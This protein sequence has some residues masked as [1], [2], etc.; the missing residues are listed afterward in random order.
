MIR[1]FWIFSVFLLVAA[2]PRFV[3]A[4]ETKT[5]FRTAAWPVALRDDL[6]RIDRIEW[7]LRAA[8]DGMCPTRSAM[9]GFS[10][11]SLRAYAAGDRSLV[12]ATTGLG[13][14]PQILA[15]KPGGPAQEA[16]L[17]AGDD[18]LAIDG[19]PPEELVAAG[20]PDAL[21]ADGMIDA[22]AEMTPGRTLS[23]TYERDGNVSTTLVRLAA[24]CSVRV[25]YKT[26]RGIRA[27]SDARNVAVTAGLVRFVESDDELAL[28]LG[29]EMAH[30]ILE[31][32]SGSGLAAQRREE[33]EADALA[34]RLVQCAGYDVEK[35]LA[36]FSRFRKRDWLGFL[37]S[38]TH[39]GTAERIRLMRS[40]QDR[41]RCPVEPMR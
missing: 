11:D 10:L 9:A 36:F 29:H 12:G 14:R 2:M 1:S 32:E 5:V 25:L 26:E 8:S 17:A 41:V 13:E 31:H 38:P 7:R 19:T 22:I 40:T 28:V 4:A 16:G 15:I 6:V 24:G 35:G 27:Y 37:R 23:V 39:R 34:V 33:D 18:L 30:I 20:T 3:E 21:I